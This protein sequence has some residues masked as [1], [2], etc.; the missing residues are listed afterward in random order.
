MFLIVVASGAAVYYTGSA[1]APLPDPLSAMTPF[2]AG[3]PLATNGT[4]SLFSGSVPPGTYD[5]FLICDKANNG[6]LD[7]TSAP[8]CPQ[9]RPSIICR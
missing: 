8:L 4:H 3:G 2:V 9:R 6:H 1:L 7:L 5:F